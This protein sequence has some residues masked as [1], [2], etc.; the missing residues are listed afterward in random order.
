MIFI[1][2]PPL[3]FLHN[4]FLC[5]II[6][7]FFCKLTKTVEPFYSP[8]STLLHL[9]PFCFFAKQDYVNLCRPFRYTCNCFKLHC[10]QSPWLLIDLLM[11]TDQKYTIVCIFCRL[12][13]FLCIV[14]LGICK[15]FSK[16]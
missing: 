10:S 6:F 1:S 12:K 7:W 14:M 11:T 9:K 3:F 2:Q 8:A 5:S 16:D 15:C 4:T 13:T